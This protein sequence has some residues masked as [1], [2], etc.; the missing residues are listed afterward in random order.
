MI[1]LFLFVFIHYLPLSTHLN[2]QLWSPH[3][4]VFAKC[5]SL[6][7]IIVRLAIPLNKSNLPHLGKSTQDT[8]IVQFLKK[9]G[10]CFLSLHCLYVAFIQSIFFQ[11]RKSPTQLSHRWYMITMVTAPT[12]TIEAATSSSQDTG[13]TQESQHTHR[14]RK[15]KRRCDIVCLLTTEQRVVKTWVQSNGERC[16]LLCVSPRLPRPAANVHSENTG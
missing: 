6:L 14:E 4:A 5:K 8:Y 3:F 12:G 10:D 11:F 9:R 16:R 1:R 15:C 2:A 13:V 7:A